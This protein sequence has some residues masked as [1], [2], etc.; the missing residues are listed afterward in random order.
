MQKYLA[1]QFAWLTFSKLLTV[2]ISY[3]FKINSTKYQ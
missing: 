1:Q 2:N 3:D